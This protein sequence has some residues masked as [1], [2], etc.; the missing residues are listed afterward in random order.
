MQGK[1][2]RVKDLQF[3]FT[4]II[5]DQSSQAKL[6]SSHICNSQYMSVVES[7]LKSTQVN[8]FL[9]EADRFA[10]FC[11]L[12]IDYC[13]NKYLYCYVCSFKLRHEKIPG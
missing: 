8:V 4:N 1:S 10:I 12:S 3:E 13:L 5:I 2:R 9:S 6:L 7:V 11:K